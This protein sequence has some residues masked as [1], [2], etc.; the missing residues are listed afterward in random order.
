MRC[1][2]TPRDDAE[3]RP[4]K[5]IDGEVVR[6]RGFSGGTSQ[7]IP[8]RVLRSYKN[9]VKGFFGDEEKKHMNGN[10]P[11]S[12]SRSLFFW[13]RMIFFI[14]MEV[15]GAQ[16]KHPRFVSDLAVDAI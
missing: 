2:S 6:L 14:G 11:S 3:L 8:Q 12:S 7:Q 4:L 9:K 15:M 16:R 5:G 1:K 13:D 10:K